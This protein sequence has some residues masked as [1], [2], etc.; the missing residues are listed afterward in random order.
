MVYLGGTAYAK[1]KSAICQAASSVLEKE[2]YTK[3]LDLV[4]NLIVESE[5]IAGNDI[6]AGILLDGPVCKTKS[7]GLS[8]EI[9]LGE[10]ATPVCLSCLLQV[11]ENTH[12][13]ETENRSMADRK[14]SMLAM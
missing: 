1:S 9:S 12:A 2:T 10:L 6:D 13:R 5:V 14:V 11:T 3:V 8:E 7:L 4:E